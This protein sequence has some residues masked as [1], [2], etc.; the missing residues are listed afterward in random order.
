MQ[1]PVHPAGL[2]LALTLKNN[3]SVLA[4]RLGFSVNGEHAHPPATLVEVTVALPHVGTHR[5]FVQNRGDP[6]V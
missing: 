3:Q 5:D 2:P 1:S 6:V 4:R